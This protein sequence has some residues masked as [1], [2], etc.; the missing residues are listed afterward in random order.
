MRNKGFFSKISVNFFDNKFLFNTK[1]KLIS[2]ISYFLF[3]FFF[4]LATSGTFFEINANFLLFLTF[5]SFFLYF[6]IYF[7]FFFSSSNHII[8]ESISVLLIYNLKCLHFLKYALI[9]NNLIFFKNVFIYVRS[10]NLLIF[11]S[12]VIPLEINLTVRNFLLSKTDY[13]E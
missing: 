13:L 5:T 4:L 10:F 8:L 11:A 2:N 3:F 12:N 7:N 1:I 9:N 6:Y